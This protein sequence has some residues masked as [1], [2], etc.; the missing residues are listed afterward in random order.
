MYIGMLLLLTF[1]LET[2]TLLLSYKSIGLY[3]IIFSIYFHA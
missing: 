2:N 1:I 3:W